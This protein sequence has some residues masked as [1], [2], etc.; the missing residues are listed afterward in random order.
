MD[1]E[2]YAL[3][4]E[5]YVA[6]NQRRCVRGLLI[7]LIF[8]VVI[9]AVF[10]LLG[11]QGGLFS[12]LCGLGAGLLLAATIFFLVIPH[13]ARSIYR[14]Q[15]SMREERV[16]TVTRDGIELVQQSGS[17][18]SSWKDF[19][20]WDETPRLIVLYANRAIFIPIVKASISD[21][22]IHAIKGH[23][24]HSGLPKPLRRRPRK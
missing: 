3:S 7:G 10:S 17:Y 4:I 8:A 13:S 16:M 5:D 22:T 1:Q 9:A 18:R 21:Q 24:V 2:K 19:I 6:Y 20:M 23:L 11:G 14:E 15:R 12:G